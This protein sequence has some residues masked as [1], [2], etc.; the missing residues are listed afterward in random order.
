MLHN[1][2]AE[3]GRAGAP[4]HE[5][6]AGEID[7]TE[8]G[9]AFGRTAIMRSPSRPADAHEADARAKARA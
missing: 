5:D 1:L 7:R 6:L 8:V 2:V 9:V 4:G 3:A